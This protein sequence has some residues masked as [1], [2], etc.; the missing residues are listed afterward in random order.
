MSLEPLYTLH[1]PKTARETENPFANVPGL[2][3]ETCL[4]HIAFTRMLP[5][6]FHPGTQVYQ[7]E[8]AYRFLLE[9]ACGLHSK[10]QGESEIFGQIKQAWKNWHAANPELSK[11]LNRTVQHLFADTKSIRTQYLH[12]IGGQSY[13]GATQKLLNLK[14]NQSVLII[15]AGQFGQMFATKLYQ[16]AGSIIVANRSDAPLKALQKS[17]PNIKTMLGHKGLSKALVEC[18]HVLVAIPESADPEINALLQTFW[19]LN[20][21]GGS[22]VHFGQ[23]EFAGTAWENLPNFYSLKAILNLQ[24][25]NGQ[26]KPAHIARAFNACGLH[27]QERAKGVSLSRR[28]SQAV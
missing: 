10:I 5:P 3:V 14:K 23:M 1:V 28:I 26:A 16:A 15:G 9:I 4:R 20:T 13:A 25:A 22:M 11:P 6:A 8:A 12:G 19:L 7:G 21:N 2:C 24:N 27:A 18:H 17:L